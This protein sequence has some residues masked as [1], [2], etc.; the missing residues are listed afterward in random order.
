[1]KMACAIDEFARYKR[2]LGCQYQGEFNRLK[3]FLR[4]TG[5]IDLKS[6]T[7]QHLESYL[8][9]NH[10]QPAVR[11]W[12]SKFQTLKLFFGFAHK[13]GYIQRDVMPISLPEGPPQFV[14]Y[15]FSVADMR[16]LLGVPDTQYPTSAPLVPKTMRT[17]LIFLFGTELRPG[18][19]M[20]LGTSDV[21]L[22]NSIL[23]VRET[24]FYK[25]RLV[26]LGAD[27][28]GVLRDYRRNHAPYAQGVEAPF[29]CNRL[30]T[31]VTHDQADH[32]FQWLRTEA[33]VLRFD[34]ARYQPR[35]HDFR[36][37]FAVTRLTSWY[38]E[39]KDVQRLLPH[40]ST[41]LGHVSIDET[42]TYLRM[43]TDLLQEANHRF[44]LYAWPKSEEVRHG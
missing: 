41:Y 8:P 10:T 13:R 36:H 40:L 5:D 26:P 3:A 28:G 1:M 34:V 22:E 44:E 37:T 14:P 18:E 23:T 11:G 31:R 39:G 24:K 19:A 43:T 35:L 20:K 2:A 16:R 33:N 7:R 42:A 30:G 32:E 29:F 9:V 21:D 27:L 17:F 6:V 4:Y 25:S 12:F 38:R 15:I